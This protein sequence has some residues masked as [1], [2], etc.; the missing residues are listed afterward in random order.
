MVAKMDDLIYLKN[1][2]DYAG[3]NQSLL[4]CGLSDVERN[5]LIC[6]VCDGILRIAHLTDG[7]Y[8]CG[9][10]VVTGED[11]KPAEANRR[12]TQLLKVKC[13]FSEQDCA[14]FGNLGELQEHLSAECS[15]LPVECP[16]GCNI[17]VSR[18]EYHLH[19]QYECNLRPTKCP[20]C[21]QVVACSVINEHYTKCLQ[22]PVSCPNSCSE[23]VITQSKLI[24]HLDNECPLSHISCPY[25]KYGCTA[26][27][28][29]RKDIQEH[30][31]ECVQDH[32]RIICRRLDKL[33]D[34]IKTN[35]SGGTLWRIELIK[36]KLT[37]GGTFAGPQFYVGLCKFQCVIISQGKQTNRI[38]FYVRMLRGDMDESLVWPF[39]GK[40]TFTLLS[41]KPNER[42]SLKY[43]FLS[44]INNPN[45]FTHLAEDNA[46]CV[47]FTI[48]NAHQHL[49]SEKLIQENSILLR[50]FV[51]IFI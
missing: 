32:L 14:W 4:V 17:S 12:A 7:G 50:A 39:K 6:V 48:N 13:P 44:E 40:M 27:K 20:Y 24:N 19:T 37:T 42:K 31:R 45:S 34:A 28:M 43:T 49:T 16:Y 9:C 5:L 46:C 41:K 2:P 18:S 3:Y 36:E 47:G 21:N 11:A 8:K 26:D 35:Q 30:E 38:S 1:G 33:D 29:P 10:C 25:L 51:E 22:V 23:A 15:H